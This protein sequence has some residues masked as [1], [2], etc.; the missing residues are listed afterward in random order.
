MNTA[1]FSK[2]QSVGRWNAE[3]VKQRNEAIQV[4]NNTPDEIKNKNIKYL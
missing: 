1:R 2:N 4:A 3:K